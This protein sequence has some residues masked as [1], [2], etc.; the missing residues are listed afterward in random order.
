MNAR[1]RAAVSCARLWRAGVHVR[2][3]AFN[4]PYAQTIQQQ[5]LWYNTGKG[6][7]FR[8]EV[9]VGAHG[10]SSRNSG[11]GSLPSHMLTFGLGL[12][13]GASACYYSLHPQGTNFPTEDRFYDCRWCTKM[14]GSTCGTVRTSQTLLAG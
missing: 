9:I 3:G 11:F 4:K 10:R 14:L 1:T 8:K 7:P 5:A 12:C 13:A 6:Q 2:G